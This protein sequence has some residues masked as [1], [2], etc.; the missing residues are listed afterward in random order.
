MHRAARVATRLACAGVIGLAIVRG[1]PAATSPASVCPTAAAVDA[2]P[3]YL[4]VGV[5]GL[6]RLG[7]CADGRPVYRPW[8][9]SASSNHRYTTDRTTRAAMIAAGWTPE[10]YGRDGVAMCDASR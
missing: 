3:L 6:M 7:A 1:A 9:A 2:K 10:G 5:G 8:N 4:P